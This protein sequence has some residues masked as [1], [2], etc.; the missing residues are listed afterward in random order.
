MDHIAALIKRA[1]NLIPNSYAPY[2]NFYV[3]CVLEMENG[4]IFDGVNV[5]NASYGLTICAERTAIATMATNIVGNTKPKLKN[6]IVLSKA[7][8]KTPPCGAC[9]QVLSEFT[10]KDT[11]LYLPY[12][13]D[14]SKVF[15]IKA[16]ELL[17]HGFTLDDK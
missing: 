9:R 15:S 5:E 6:I 16:N 14:F 8:V 17:P 4:E 2:S 10:S 11:M 3:T 12:G 1:I 13:E 7:Q